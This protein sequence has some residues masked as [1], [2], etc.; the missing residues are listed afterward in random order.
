M[1]N[2]D[3]IEADYAVGEFAKVATL[4]KEYKDKLKSIL[5]TK[6]HLNS[7]LKKSKK[8]VPVPFFLIMGFTL[9]LLEMKFEKNKGYIVRSLVSC[10]FPITKALLNNGGIENII[11]AVESIKVNLYN[12]N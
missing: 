2:L 11:N 8:S 3:S 6:K 7:L 9:S 1:K 5:V 12:V 4:N 10:S